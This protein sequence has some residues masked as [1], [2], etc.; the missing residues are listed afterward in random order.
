MDMK[1]NKKEEP[2]NNKITKDDADFEVGDIMMESSTLKDG[3]KEVKQLIKTMILG[4]KTVVWCVSNY[5]RQ[6]SVKKKGGSSK[7]ITLKE[8]DS[9]S[10]CRNLS[11]ATCPTMSLFSF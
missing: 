7:S 2:E 10:Q 11:R 1:G 3:I 4:L 5:L 8:K 6:G 9:R